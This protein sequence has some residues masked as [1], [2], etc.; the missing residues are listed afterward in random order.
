MTRKKPILKK[1]W[2]NRL[3]VFHRNNDVGIEMTST[4]T[5]GL[6]G[7]A[8]AADGHSIH[9]DLNLSRLNDAGVNWVVLPDPHDSSFLPALEPLDAV[10]SFGHAPFRQEE[11]DQLPRLKHLARFGSGYESIDVD[12]CTQRGVM[13]SNTPSAVAVPV[14]HAA[15]T[16]L[17]TLSHRLFDKDRITRNGE[18]SQRQEYR[19]Y[20]LVGQTLGIL[21]F[22]G[23]ATEL[24]K[25]AQPLG[26]RVIGSTRSGVSTAAD[27]L[28]VELV[29]TEELA[30]ESDYLVLCAPATAETADIVDAAFLRQMKSSAHLI[31]VARGSLVNEEDLYE[32]LSQG[33][34]RGAGLD[35]FK[36]EPIDPADPLLTLDNV[37]VAPHAL[38]WTRDFTENVSARAIAD[39]IASSRG[40]V[41]AGLLNPEVLDHPNLRSAVAKP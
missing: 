18:W 38:C 19:G 30:R 1:S 27:Q 35:V 3:Q 39:V 15:L 26:L 36:N 11:L 29:S 2:P 4:Y 8:V 41:P 6:T 31:N 7:D 40:E 9:G 28:G 33:V 25:I 20:G 5:V 34:I 12:A 22:G 10:L 13:V 21:G 23:I 17:L 14:A 32:A 24:A 37:V 16:L